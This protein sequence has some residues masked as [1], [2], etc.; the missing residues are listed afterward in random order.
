MQA[1]QKKS[2]GDTKEPNILNQIWFKYFPYWPLFVI[3]LA[4]VLPGAWLYVKYKT[5]PMYEATATI[6]IKD[7]KKGQDDSKMM[8]QIN[9]LNSK[10]IIENEIE[11]IKSRELMYQVVKNRHLYAQFFQKGK[12]RFVCAY[13]TSPVTI[14]AKNP[15]SLRSSGEVFFTVDDAKT[16]ITIGNT[17]YALNEWVNT[18]Y[19]ILKFIPQSIV[20]TSKPD[21]F[22]FVL[23]NP[24]GIAVGLAANLSATSVN[25]FASVISLKIQDENYKRAEDILNGLIESYNYAA[26][27]DKNTLAAKTLGFVDE[28]LKYVEHDLDSIEKKLQQYKASRGAVDIGSQGSLYL[29]NVSEL[30]K[31]MGDVSVRLDVLNQVESYVKSKDNSGG[32]VPSTLGVNDP[33]LSQLLE[34]VNNK[35]LEYQRLIKT[36]GENNPM[37]LSLKSEIDKLTPGILENVQNQKQSLLVS[38]NNISGLAG[39]FSSMLSSIPQKERDLVEI[40]REQNIKSGVY[41]FL[42]Q[43]REET[44]LALSASMS[45]SRT[46]D[47]AQSYGPNSP[48]KKMYI[49]AVF[50]A[51]ALGIGLISAND[52]LK[53]TILYR[54]EIE[55]YTS[56][57]IIG[58]IA[59]DKSKEPLVI[60]NGKRTFIAEQFRN[61]RTSLPYIGIKGDKKK[62]LVTST[63]SGEGKSFIVANLGVSLAMTGKKVVVLEFDLSNPTLSDKLSI[64]TSEGKGLADYI[65]GTVRKD[66]IVMQTEVQENLYIIP[67][68]TLPDNPSELITSEKVPELINYLSVFYD[69]IIID[70]APVG[71]L[72]DAYILSSYCDASLYVVRHKHTPKTAIQR[73]DENNRINEL[74][75]I[76]IVFNGVTSR[77]FGANAYGYGYG[78]GYGYVY[79]EKGSKK[80]KGL[81]KVG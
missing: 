52:L 78:Y 74:K 60:G 17:V 19:G 28:R 34:K 77:G 54:Q 13:T 81:R 37:A 4:I 27:Q 45:D 71:L 62:L 29:Q 32:I 25:K 64:T 33:M 16:K 55:K 76:A 38:R 12:I 48:A 49:M 69:Y 22:Y 66:E 31:Q 58:E 23:E 2:T 63:I 21:P 57:P 40:S 11:V 15:D 70:T 1:I 80:K 61:L 14:E 44:A 18:P 72:S 46:I 67:A 79:K 73:I 42:L 5:T 56:V 51:F 36:T 41:N 43:K 53:R 6:L 50:L 3:L 65:K 30:N 10:K 24:Q 39:Q 20:R 8:E 26:L 75:N 59:F 9:Q 68:G 7:E 47:N 35:Q